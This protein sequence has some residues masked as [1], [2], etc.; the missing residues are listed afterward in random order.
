[1]L[2]IKY[3]FFLK[4]DTFQTKLDTPQ[5]RIVAFQIKLSI[6]Q[7]KTSAL[8]LNKRLVEA[9]GIIPVGGKFGMPFFDFFNS[10]VPVSKHAEV[11]QKFY[12]LKKIVT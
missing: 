7:V 9:A 11:L 6:F 3:P 12:F 2:Y 4:P 1:M 8:R 5:S 10:A